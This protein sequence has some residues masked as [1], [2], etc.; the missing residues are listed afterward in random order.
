MCPGN[1]DGAVTQ[2]QESWTPTSWWQTGADEHTPLPNL[3]SG[4]TEGPLSVCLS[5]WLSV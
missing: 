2:D 4:I 3:G 1:D 5:A